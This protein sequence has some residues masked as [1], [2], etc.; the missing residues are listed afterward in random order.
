MRI[1]ELPAHARPRERAMR[2]GVSRLSFEDL[3][4]I[5]IQSGIKE[6]S[7]REVAQSL[8][9]RYPTKRELSQ[10][11][12][13][14]LKEISGIGPAKA[15]ELLSA[16]ELGRRLFLESDWKEKIILRTSSDTFQYM[17]G[18]YREAKQ[19]MFYCLYLNSQCELIERRLL[20]MGTINRSLV[21]PREVFKYAYLNSAS[22]IICV[23]NH[24]SNDLKPSREDSQLTQ[25]LVELGKLNAIPVVDHLI[26]GE[27]GYYS[28]YEDGKIFNM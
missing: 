11:T 19:E 9:V 3:L 16:V 10:I 27:D 5:L 13:S 20:F 25:A 23:H 7:A 22:S 21:H 6:K 28:F 2:E 1:K 26:V 24:P 17:K 18:L 8:L 12:F 14:Q 15:I 4:T